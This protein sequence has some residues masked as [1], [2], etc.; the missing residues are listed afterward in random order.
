MV[1]CAGFVGFVSKKIALKQKR[2]HFASFSIAQR[3]TRTN[4][5][6]L[7]A[8]FASN[9]LFRLNRSHFHLEAKQNKKESHIVS[10]HFVFRFHIGFFASFH[11][12]FFHFKRKKLNFA[13]HCLFRFK[14]GFLHHFALHFFV[15]F[16]LYRFISHCFASDFAFSLQ[17]ETSKNLLYSCFQAK[18]FSISLVS[19]RNRK[20]AAHPICIFTL[21]KE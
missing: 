11:F 9:F 5:L 18:R 19:L 3:K 17:C 6:R 8:Y 10:Q 16:S 20:R 13:L 2:I 4:F 12:A 1:G 7:F 14:T 15:S 21:Y